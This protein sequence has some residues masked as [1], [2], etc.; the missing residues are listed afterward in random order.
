MKTFKKPH[1]KPS[2]VNALIPINR[3]LNLHGMKWLHWLP[4]VGKWPIIRGF[5]D[6]TSI[7]F[8]LEHKAK[9]QSIVREDTA[10]FIGPNHP[11]FYT[12]WML[13]KEIS[14]EC[15]P[16]MAS[17]ATHTIVN[18]MGPWMQDFWLSN[19]LIAQI[20]GNTEEA[21][22]FSI[23]HAL[24][25][26]GVLLH[27]EGKVEWHSNTIG[28]LYNGIIDMAYQAKQLEPH[29]QVYIAP[30]VWKLFY[31]KKAQNNLHSDMDDIEHQ[32][33]LQSTS[34]RPLEDRLR[35]MLENILRQWSGRYGV[36]FTSNILLDM[37]QAIKSAIHAEIARQAG[38]DTTRSVKDI[39]KT[40]VTERSE[41]EVKNIGRIVKEY[42]NIDKWK[43]EY[44][45]KE[46]LTHE[47]VGEW[48]QVI[49]IS[50]LHKGWKNV[51]HKFIPR[52]V[53]SRTARIE[54]PDPIEV[55]LS[56]PKEEVKQ[57]MAKMMQSQLDS[58]NE[59][60]QRFERI[61]YIKNTL[62]E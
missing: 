25:G 9:L 18:G 5:C 43:F 38:Y 14:A 40:V 39:F 13:D 56:M 61:H 19:G 7:D 23:E 50:M 54:V 49:R 21:K 37:H 4:I 29:K 2:L 36:H 41:E 58:I 32:M 10:V 31:N 3:W 1:I 35:A 55:D 8:P 47:E 20:P 24:K 28:P 33:G 15:A 6:I 11:E 42:D 60:L 48:L 16:L 17:W 46:V 51:F 12:D 34:N 53:Q 57:H 44:Y 30:V 45:T 62:K 27:P 59:Q 52:P 22:A 26:H